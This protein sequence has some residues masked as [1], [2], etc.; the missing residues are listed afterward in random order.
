[1]PATLLTFFSAGNRS[2]TIYL[3]KYPVKVKIV[4]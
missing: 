3:E 4:I 1:M 2:I